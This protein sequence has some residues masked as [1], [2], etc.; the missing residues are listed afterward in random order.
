MDFVPNHLVGLIPPVDLPSY[1]P[2]CGRWALALSLSLCRLSLSNKS[3]NNISFITLGNHYHFYFIWFTLTHIRH[4]TVCTVQRTILLLRFNFYLLALPTQR[5]VV[6]SVSIDHDRVSYAKCYFAVV[7]FFCSLCGALLTIRA[8]T[9]ASC[10]LSRVTTTRHKLFFLN[11]FCAEQTIFRNVFSRSRLVVSLQR[12]QKHTH[13]VFS[14][15]MNEYDAKVAEW[16]STRYR[17][18]GEADIHTI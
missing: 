5:S 2:C 17:S 14:F 6:I 16:R 18:D 11:F 9:H 4:H 7:C 13:T 3:Y 12:T 10:R 8:T 1:R 15:A